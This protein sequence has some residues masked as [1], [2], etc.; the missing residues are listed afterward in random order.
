M[1]APIV[2]LTDFGRSD[3]FVGIMKGVILSRCPWAKIVDLTH[4]IPP[5]D[6]RSAAFALMSAV[7]Y[8]PKDSLF[9]CVVDPGV[10]SRRPVLYARSARHRFLA[11]DN[12]ILSWAAR[13]GAFRELRG[14]TNRRLFL[15]KPSSTFHGR[16]V[17][18]P[19][20]AAL[21]SGSRPEELGPRRKAMKRMAFPSV[22]RA[23]RRLR[24]EVL[25]VDHFGNATTNLKPEALRRGAC[26][27]T[28]G[29]RLGALRTSYCSVAV[30]EPAALVGSAGF[31][32]L[33]IR[34]GNF[35]AAFGVQAGEPVYAG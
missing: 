11:P 1:N 32:E 28:A 4:G 14:V 19:V 10:G 31:V 21:A 6:I 8:F 29:C 34:E 15:P 3:P 5:Q 12:G 22:R 33:A 24:G 2:L 27:E 17:F 13:A 7:P 23:G 26:L 35:A 16:D 18:A 9:V 20:A 25:A 30:G